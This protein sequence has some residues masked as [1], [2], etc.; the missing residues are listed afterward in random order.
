[1]E[2]S[3]QK[4]WV[5]YNSWEG[6]P[7]VLIKGSGE[8]DESCQWQIIGYLDCWQLHKLDFSLTARV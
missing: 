8:R 6:L 1:M 4:S 5:V 3:E 7:G 2:I